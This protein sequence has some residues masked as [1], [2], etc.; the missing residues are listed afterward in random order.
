MDVGVNEVDV[1][2]S[3]LAK[4]VRVVDGVEVVSGETVTMNVCCM[5]CL[6]RSYF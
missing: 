1:E 4:L 6:T 2:A 5:G 3:P